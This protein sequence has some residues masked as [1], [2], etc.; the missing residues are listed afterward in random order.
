[1]RNLKKLIES[2]GY[3]LKCINQHKIIAFKNGLEVEKASCIQV[4]AIKL[5]L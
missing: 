3:N 2:K 4:L 1:M 5:G